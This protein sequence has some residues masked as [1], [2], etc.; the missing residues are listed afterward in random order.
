MLRYI[1]LSVILGPY[2]TLHSQALIV[3]ETM[4]HKRGIYRNLS[5][6]RNNAPGLLSEFTVERDNFGFEMTNHATQPQVKLILTDALTLTKTDSVWGFC[7]G[8]QVYISPELLYS[9]RTK[10]NRIL[11]LGRYCLF[12]S[13]NSSYYIPSGPPGG[14]GLGGTG[15]FVNQMILDFNNGGF[16]TLEKSLLLKILQND[17]ELLNQFKKEKY[18]TYKLYDYV[19][20]YSKKHTDQI[21]R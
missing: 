18:K 11:F 14:S 19:I 16:F 9:K 8:E 1:L 12:E 17:T 6:F 4:I 3:D 20:L 13:V 7:D 2:L 10:Y 21:E 5:E 15:R